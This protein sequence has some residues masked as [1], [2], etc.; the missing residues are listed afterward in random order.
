MFID[1]IFTYI[2]KKR[3]RL[4]KYQRIVIEFKSNQKLKCTIEHKYCYY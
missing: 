1:I 3:P 2:I 4:Q